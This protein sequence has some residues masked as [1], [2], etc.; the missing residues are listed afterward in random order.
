MQKVLKNLAGWGLAAMLMTATFSSCEKDK[1]GSPEVSAG[2]MSS[3]SIDPGEAGG[4][5]LITLTGSGIGQIRSVVFEK[6]NVPAA[7][8]PTLNT[9]THLIFHVPDTAFGGPQNVI[10]MWT[11]RNF[12]FRLQ[13]WP[14]QA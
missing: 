12:P 5:E 10:P 9:E 8:Q 2:N 13:C 3:G 4:G 1:D 6:N 14:L 11:E 7:F